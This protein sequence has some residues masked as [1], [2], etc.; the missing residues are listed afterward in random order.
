MTVTV[1][2]I[3][4]RTN[5]DHDFFWESK[6]PEP[7]NV[8][9]AIIDLA[10]VSDVGHSFSKSQ[11]GL[12]GY[13]TFTVP[14]YEYWTEF[15]SLIRWGVHG[16]LQVRND[17]FSRVGHNLSMEIKNDETQEVIFQGVLEVNSA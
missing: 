10:G 8:C 6:E 4:T 1:N 12:T 2:F 11:D 15:M 14:T 7:L 17:Y 3:M 9:T 13:S 16:S 5:L